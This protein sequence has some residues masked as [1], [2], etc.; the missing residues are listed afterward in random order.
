MSTMF[1]S[2][3]RPSPEMTTVYQLLPTLS[4]RDAVGNSTL[5]LHWLLGDLGY[6]AHVFAAN[7]HHELLGVAKPLSAFPEDDSWCIYHHSIGGVT[8]DVYERRSGNRILVYHNIT[9][10]GFLERW[11]ADVGAEI[12]LGRDQLSRYR[13]TTDLAVCDSD[14]NRSEVVA[15]GY[16]QSVTIPV[17]F[18]PDRL[19]RGTRTSKA[20]ATRL[21][22]VGRLAPNK[23][24]HDLVAMLAIYR[25]R[26]DPTAELH[27]VGSK[28]FDSYAT[29]LKNYVETLGLEHAVFVHDDV[30]DQELADHYASADVF[31]C[32]SD[33]EGFCV[34]LI[35]AMHHQLPVV[36]FD[37]AAVGGT[38]GDGGLLLPDKSPDVV[39]DAVARVAGDSLLATNMRTAGQRRS[40]HFALSNTRQRWTTALT[41][42]IGAPT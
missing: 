5:E 23:A 2:W 12:S 33:H 27:L 30:S 34:P 19:Q 7:I 10:I 24:Q 9:P 37:A 1:R 21:L 4:P 35:E 36:A 6:D 39:A 3:L 20:S 11:S 38:L 32:V 25:E 29:A 18:E 41:D 22:F 40:E 15:L 17:M 13:S 31:V 16:P 42:T 28:T 14:Y 26:H 8:G